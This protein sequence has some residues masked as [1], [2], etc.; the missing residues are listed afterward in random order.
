MKIFTTCEIEWSTKI[1]TILFKYGDEI[2]N[3]FKEKNYSYDLEELAL[4]IVCRPKGLALKQRKR[5]DAR[6]KI[7]YID[8]MLDYGLVASSNMTEREILFFE[9]FRQIIPI[10]EKYKKKIVG[11]QI[12]KFKEDLDSLLSQYI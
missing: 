11:L 8:I 9:G 2:G 4:I 6:N 12:E 5:Y 7:L 1:D 10:L 3:F